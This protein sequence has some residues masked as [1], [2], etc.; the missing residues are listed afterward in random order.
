MLWYEEIKDN[1]FG[2]ALRRASQYYNT[3][4]GRWPN[5]VELPL[6]WAGEA[7]EFKKRLAA[8]GRNGIEIEV[9]KEILARHLKVVFDSQERS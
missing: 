5:R 6:A 9:R 1:G 4:Y 8:E 7:D 2:E 3:K